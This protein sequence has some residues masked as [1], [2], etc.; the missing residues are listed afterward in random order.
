MSYF[1]LNT[2]TTINEIYLS[3][4]LITLITSNKDQSIFDTENK[5]KFKAKQGTYIE[6]TKVNGPHFDKNYFGFKKQANSKL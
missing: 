3:V 1:K 5:A 4:L 6:V 2:A